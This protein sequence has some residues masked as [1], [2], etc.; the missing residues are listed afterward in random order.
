MNITSVFRVNLFTGI[1]TTARELDREVMD[2]YKFEIIAYKHSPLTGQLYTDNATICVR[3]M[4]VNDV[5]PHFS[6]EVYTLEFDEENPPG[7]VL[8]TINA[9][10]SDQGV[11]SRLSYSIISGNDSI[12]S[13]NSSTGEMIV[14]TSLDFE[15]DRQLN[16]TVQAKDLGTPPLE[17]NVSVVINIRDINDNPPI[18]K[19]NFSGRLTLLESVQQGTFVIKINATDADSG[20]NS[21]LSFS[22]LDGNLNGAFNINPTIGLITTATWLDYEKIQIYALN[23]TVHDQGTPPLSSSILVKI[24]VIDVNDMTPVINPLSPLYVR[25]SVPVGT[26][27]AQV[28]ATDGDSGTNAVLNYTIV[29]GE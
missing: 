16:L 14:L 24:Q 25:E 5:R 29:S 21:N 2:T 15:K 1:I 22:I 3:V 26:M 10:D 18:I 20:Q 7:A 23:V 11:N 9:N 8:M 6:K 19:G 4:D 28:N 17:A 12:I 13:I 27:I